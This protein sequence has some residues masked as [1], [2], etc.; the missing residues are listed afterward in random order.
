MKR[1]NLL[2][3]KGTVLIMISLAVSCKRSIGSRADL[4]GYINNPENGLIKTLEIGDIKAELRYKPWQLM[5]AD[6]NKVQKEGCKYVTIQHKYYFVLSLSTHNKELLRQMTFAQYSEMVQVLA[7]RM[8]TYV[9]IIPD[10][11]KPVSP[12]EC[13]FQQT[14]GMAKANQLLLVFDKNKIENSKQFHI[15]IREFG[16]GT[17]D[18]N[19]QMNTNDIKDLPVAVLN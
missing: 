5:K 8:T 16:L 3:L 18:L 10:Y 19:F 17:G 15:K 4:V 14:Y 9:D 6:G 12:E 7:F 13:L 2:L 1:M 11:D